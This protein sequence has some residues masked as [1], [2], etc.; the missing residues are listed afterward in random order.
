MLPRSIVHRKDRK[1]DGSATRSN[2]AAGPVRRYRVQCRRR[3]R[4]AGRV[5]SEWSGQ[6]TFIR[7]F[8][9]L[10]KAIATFNRI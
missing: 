4:I 3:Q 2:G 1:L 5:Q 10:S 7:Q 6:H 8:K 9:S